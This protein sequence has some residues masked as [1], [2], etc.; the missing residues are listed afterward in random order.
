MDEVLSNSM[1]PQRFSTW[2]L[3]IFAAIAMVLA[4]TGIY[5]VMSY[6]VSQRTHEIGIRMA[7]GAS[8]GDVLKMV[9]GRGMVLTSIGVVIGLGAAFGVTQWMSS[10][11]F[12]VTATD[13]VTFVSIPLILV[14]VALVA[15]F[16]PARR[17]TKIDPIQAL[18]YE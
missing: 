10:L 3:G 1:A 6:S 4:A 15:C 13:V 11:L 16:I 2:M 8:R 5:G 17:A 9:T 18:R 12:G 7:L 14:I